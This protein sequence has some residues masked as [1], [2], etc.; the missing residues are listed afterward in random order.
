MYVLR[1][2]CARRVPS[3]TQYT[4]NPAN[5][6]AAT[7][8]RNVDGFEFTSAATRKTRSASAKESAQTPAPPA[9]TIPT[10]AKSVDMPP[11]QSTRQKKPKADP[12]SDTSVEHAT[13]ATTEPRRKSSRNSTEAPLP[14]DQSQREASPT[15]EVKTRRKTAKTPVAEKEKI[16][17][18]RRGPSKI[19]LPFADTP[20]ITRNK[21]MRK[22]SAEGHRRS[23][24]SMRGRRASSLIDSGTS[25]GEQ[26]G[27]D[28]D[29]H[30]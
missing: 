11:P 20:V 22:H 15:K 29:D 17:E 6:T 8:D 9:Q 27:D 24:S 26:N 12:K 25:N 2:L 28:E 10:A 5:A 18:E 14:Q 7:Y 21:E 19:P 16:A 3:I 4:W 30:H 1:K 23:S 13:K